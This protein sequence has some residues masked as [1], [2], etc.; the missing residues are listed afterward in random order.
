M[1]TTPSQRMLLHR[2]L[3]HTVHQMQVTLRRRQSRV[4][5][6]PLNDHQVRARRRVVGA[7]RMPQRV[8]RRPYDASF[9]VVLAQH[10][11]HVSRV[12][13]HRPPLVQ[14][15]AKALALEA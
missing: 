4:S 11:P 5:S 13:R 3:H 12:Q 2:V 6:R 7:E 1:A 10:G 15:S 9:G 14:D 8:R